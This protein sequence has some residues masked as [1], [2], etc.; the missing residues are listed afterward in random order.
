MLALFLSNILFISIGLIKFAP[1]LVEIKNSTYLFTLD[2]RAN[3]EKWERGY[4]EGRETAEEDEDE[5]K[6]EAEMKEEWGF[7]AYR[8]E[9]RR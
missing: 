2:Q 8:H 7:G 1:V 6:T 9:N 4:S 3:K 5:R